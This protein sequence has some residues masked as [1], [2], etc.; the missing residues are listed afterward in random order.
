MVEIQCVLAMEYCGT[1]EDGQRFSVLAS[2]KKHVLGLGWGCVPL[3]S[4]CSVVV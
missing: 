1:V 4:R 3:C 2:M